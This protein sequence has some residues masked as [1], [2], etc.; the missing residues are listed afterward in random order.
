M[1]ESTGS[2]TPPETAL[3]R[4]P[5]WRGPVTIGLASA[6]LAAAAYGVTQTLARHLITTSAPFQVGATYTILFGMI[7]LAAMSSTSLK[8]DLRAPRAEIMWMALAG[9]ASSF[10]VLFMFAALSRAPVTLA[11]PIAAINPLIAIALTH[12]FLQRVERVSPRMV[13]GA[14]LVFAGVVLVVLGKT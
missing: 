11:S 10:G 4:P 7:I 12:L 6:L 1:T 5:R 2:E 14:L 8:R 9:I 3:H 13:A